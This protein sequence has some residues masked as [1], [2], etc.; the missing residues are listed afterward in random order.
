MRILHVVPSY[1]PAIRFGGPIYSVHGLCNALA[2]AGHDVHVY[3]TSVDGPRDL[4]VP[5]EKEV[6]V[7]KVKVRY[8][9]SRHLRRIYW[10]PAMRCALRQHIEEFDAVHLHSIFLWPT[11][12]AAR[13]AHRAHV[14]YLVAPRGM[15]VK[16][17]VRMKGWL[18]KSI[19]LSLIERSTL[20]Q[21]AALHATSDVERDD[22]R[23]F[24]YALPP[25][26][27]VPNGVEAPP[28]PATAPEV[29]SNSLLFLGRISWKKGLDRLIPALRW[30][31][32]VTLNVA[33]ND[34][35][36]LLPRL[37]LIACEHGVS[38]RV[39]FLG[40]V[41][42]KAKEEL[43]CRASILVLPSWNENFGNV[44][45]EA[46]ACGRPVAVTKEV[47][48]AEA[49]AGARAGIVIPGEAEDMATALKSLL[50][51]PAELTFMGQRG[52]AWVE[53]TFAWPAVAAQMEAVYRR[54]SPAANSTTS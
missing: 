38:D 13:V 26:C 18:R 10:A 5:L 48:L 31:P 44:V 19:W 40:S 16:E 30:M 17:M 21:A 43:L 27:V 3:T 39:R 32:D 20:E 4:D 47:G 1:Y 52:R 9:Q 34:D 41:T 49:V 22:M 51:D 42:G 35:E 46:L 37:S 7:D 12:V 33:G 36:G 45:L 54:V 23:R 6:M 8:F 14:P 28:T 25:I 50:S 29:A 2:E 11:W 53:Q 15:L 24:S